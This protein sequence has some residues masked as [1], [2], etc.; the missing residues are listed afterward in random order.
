MLDLAERTGDTELV[1]RR[2]LALEWFDQLDAL[3]KRIFSFENAS[4]S[5]S[6]E[7]FEAFQQIMTETILP[8]TY[9]SP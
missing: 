2:E 6:F 7:Q 9:P 5:V 1:S 4:H 3:I 8:E